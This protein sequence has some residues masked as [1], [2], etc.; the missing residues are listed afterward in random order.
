MPLPQEKTVA[1]T[2]NI[3][4][5]LRFCIGSGRTSATPSATGTKA[6]RRG[7]YFFTKKT[8]WQQLAGTSGNLQAAAAV[9]RNTSVT[10]AFALIVDSD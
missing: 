8:S 1:V 6:K 2:R 10:G 7:D 3:Q 4:K 9:V 5:N